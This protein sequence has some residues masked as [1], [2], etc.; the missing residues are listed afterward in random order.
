MFTKACR[1]KKKKNQLSDVI[2]ALFS[3]LASIRRKHEFYRRL[4]EHDDIL[5]DEDTPF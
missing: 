2:C 1:F 5:P 3:F 4:T